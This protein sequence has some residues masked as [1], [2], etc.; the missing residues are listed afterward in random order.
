MAL[1]S[2]IARPDVEEV[3]F[4]GN[5]ELPPPVRGPSDGSCPHENRALAK[6]VVCVGYFFLF[7]PVLVERIGFGDMFFFNPEAVWRLMRTATHTAL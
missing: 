7:N 2:P 1:G 3:W 4:W 5:L 6:V